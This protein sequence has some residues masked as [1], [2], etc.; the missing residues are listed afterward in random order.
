MRSGNSAS[1]SIRVLV[2]EDF[3]S[4]R[5]FLAS[6]LQQQPELQ[7]ICEVG[8]GLEGVKKAQELQ[9]DLVLLDIGLPKLNGIE[10]A[11]RIR[12]LSPNSA[13]LF[14]TQEM[15]T[16]VVEA[17][18]AT[19]AGG[20]VVKMDAEGELLTAINAVL[21][22][23]TFVSSRCARRTLADR[24]DDLSHVVA[25]ATPTRPR[26]AKKQPRHIAGFYSDD[27]SFLKAFTDFIGANLKFGSAVIVVGTESHRASLL[28]RL[29]LPGLDIG[30]AIEQ[31]RYISLD[32]AET[33]STFMVNHEPD[34]VRFMKGMRELIAAAAKTA[35]GEHPRVAAC[36]EC[37]PLLCEQG[38]ADA[39]IRLEQLWDEV[40][41]SDDVDILCGYSL[42]S[43]QGERGRRILEKLRAEHSDIHYR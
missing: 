29:Q 25:S 5:L 35:T 36:G 19:G 2:V 37:A 39:A 22:G 40:A 31:G 16:A 12:K 3:P 43:L 14:V 34:P 9:P 10:V 24:T 32:V 6:K 1:S 13:I 4:F 42:G 27:A 7:V 23:E 18:L 30:E 33:L 11:R 28:S 38:N 8:D 15:S 41:S 21:R 26:Q 20:Y 17:G